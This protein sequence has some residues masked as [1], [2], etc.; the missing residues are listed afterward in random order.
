MERLVC[1]LLLVNKEE[2]EKRRIGGR[3]SFAALFVFFPLLCFPSSSKEAT[4]YLAYFSQS[5]HLDRRSR[6]RI[7]AR[8]S[9]KP[10]C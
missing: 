3:L 6:S 4:I 2:I 1:T 10:K 5:P 8:F 9:K 7:I